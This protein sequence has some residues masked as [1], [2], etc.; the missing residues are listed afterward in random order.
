VQAGNEEQ[1]STTIT[2]ALLLLTK[3]DYTSAGY[4]LS[5]QAS[6]SRQDEVYDKFRHDAANMTSRQGSAGNQV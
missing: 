5:R 2:N 6:D 1:A 4:M 3:Y